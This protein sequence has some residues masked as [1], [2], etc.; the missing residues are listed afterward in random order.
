MPALRVDALHWRA[1]VGIDLDVRPGR[2][3]IEVEAGA[4]A[5]T[6][7]R[8]A[9]ADGAAAALSD[10]D[11]EGGRSVRESAAGRRRAHRARGPGTGGPVAA[12][13]GRVAMVR[14]IRPARARSR[15]QPVRRSQRLQRPAAQPAR[16]RRFP[17]SGRNAGRRRPTLRRWCW[18]ATCTSWDAPSCSIT[19]R[20]CSRFWLTCRRS[21][22][23]GR[24][25][26]GGADRRPRRRHGTGHRSAP[27]LGGASRRRAGRSAVAGGASQSA[28]LISEQNRLRASSLRAIS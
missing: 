2:Y 10:P 13:R 21:T 19:A 15:Q 20:A 7:P 23:N 5:T 4:A 24:A 27:P 18:R 6:V 3:P 9:R 28:S 22:C 11:A 26:R 16:R 25:R 8:D 12:L 17:E 1:L 14:R